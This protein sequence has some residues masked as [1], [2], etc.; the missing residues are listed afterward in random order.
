[1]PAKTETL[2]ENQADLREI[3]VDVVDRAMKAGA[4]LAEA[5]VRDGTEFSTLVRMGEV[6][7]L[8]ES[9][10][11]ALGLRVFLGQQYLLQ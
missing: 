1:M 7:T 3:A 11:R 6:E 4:T 5:V 2:L 8:K 10:S 9:G